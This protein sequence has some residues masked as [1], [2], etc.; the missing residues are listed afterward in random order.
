MA[1]R[2]EVAGLHRPVRPELPLNVQQVLHGVRGS[3]VVSGNVG[4]R[5]RYLGNGPIPAGDGVAPTQA[6]ISNIRG[7]R[8]SSCNIACQVEV[9]GVADV[10]GVEE[11]PAATDHGLVA[12]RVS[13]ADARSE[14]RAL[15]FHEVVMQTAAAACF[16]IGPT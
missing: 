12:E 1:L 8:Y 16:R 11:T 3:V 13:N 7:E 14:I 10:L 4:V 2:P 15:G 5:R 6:R 9:H